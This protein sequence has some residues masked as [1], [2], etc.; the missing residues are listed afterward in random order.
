MQLQ[1][2]IFVIFP[3]I[4]PGSCILKTKH[5]P[6]SFKLLVISQFTKTP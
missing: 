6:S 2:V 5:L 4:F 3:F 1:Y